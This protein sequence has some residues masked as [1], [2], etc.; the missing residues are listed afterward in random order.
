VPETAFPTLRTRAPLT[1]AG[2]PTTVLTL[3][4]YTA[5][6]KG[7]FGAMADEFLRLYPASND[8]EA[9]LQNNEAARD[10]GRIST[11]LWARERARWVKLPMYTYFWNHALTGPSKTIRG[12]FHGSELHYVFNSL[13][14]TA[15]PWTPD[16]RH[17]ADVMSSYWANITKTGNPNGPGLPHWP[18]Y[19]TARAQV[20]VVG[21]SFGP[22]TIATPAKRAFWERFFNAQD[23]W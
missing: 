16:D 3:A 1:R 17:I 8:D 15:L 21:D 6:A 19:S 2:A 18:A 11:W 22:Q 12:A 10:N 9:G 7:K 13:H 14:A 20:M 23:Q 4:E 5:W